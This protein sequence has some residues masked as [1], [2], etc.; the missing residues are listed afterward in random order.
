MRHT[1]SIPLLCGAFV[2]LWSSGFIGGKFGL[3]YAGTFTLLFWRY[4]LVVLILGV[5]VLA[6]GK[7]QNLSGREICRHAV[8]G[9]LTYAVGLGAIF[10]AMDLG[11]SAGL[12]AFIIALQPILTGALQARLT[13]EA[14]SRREWLGLVLGIASV[15]IVIGDSISL[16]GSLLAH[17]LPFLSV[18]AITLATLIDRGATVGG[19]NQASV[20]LATFWHNAASL[21][22]LTPLAIGAEGLQAQWGGNLIFAIA[23]LALVLSLGAYVL[24]FTLL[25]KLT[26]AR[27]ASL[28][29]LSPPVT[30]LMA[31]LAFGE[32]VTLAGLAGLAL[33]AVAVWLCSR[34]PTAT[35]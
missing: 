13:G 25:R 29:Y 11:L 32:S 15:G 1:A 2:V 27:F 30:M 24:M 28:L 35:A 20:L 10:H 19:K 9:S 17:V 23:W 31:W 34:S 26:A 14:V 12:A 7:W 8:V 22:V 18:A 16:G 5:V 21:A 3:G 6:L 33:A 4:V